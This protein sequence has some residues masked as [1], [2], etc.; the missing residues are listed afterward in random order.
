MANLNLGFQGSYNDGY[1]RLSC[2]L[3]ISDCAACAADYYRN[4]CVWLGTSEL[5]DLARGDEKEGDRLNRRAIDIFPN[6]LGPVRNTIPSRNV[7]NR[8]G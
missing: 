8:S 6:R 2:N 3:K 5:S 4:A 7:E 1:K